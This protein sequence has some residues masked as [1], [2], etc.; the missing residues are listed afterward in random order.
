MEVELLEIRDFLAAQRP[1]DQLPDDALSSVPSTLSIRYVRRDHDIPDDD[2]GQPLLSV[3]RTGAAE[4]RSAGGE[5]LAR[6][7][8]GDLLGYRASP[9]DGTQPVR[10]VA[11]E[12][13]L[14]YQLPAQVVDRLC[15]EH[16]QFAYFF[17]PVG[18][19]RLRD[20]VR[21]LGEGQETQLNLMTT[22]LR[23]LIAR[24]PV[25]LPPTATIRETAER[26]S[27]ER[28]SSML[29]VE[30]GFLFGVVTDRD[31]RLR[32]IAQGLD[33]D[34]PVMEIMTG[35]PWTVDITAFAYEAL[36]FMA[37][38]GVHHLPVLDGDRVAGMVTATDF[39]ERH[40]TSAVYLAGDIY[41]QAT[42]A[43][44]QS[45]SAR[46]PHLFLNLAAAGATAERVGHV[47]TGVGDAVT[48]RLLELAE[49]KMGPP[50]VDYA[51]VTAG[52]QARNEQSVGSDQDN[53]L[54]LDD[55]YDPAA[56]GDYFREFTRFVCDGL[57]S[58]GYVH[59]P[60]DMMAMTD[61]WRLSLKE[62]QTKFVGWIDEP[63]PKSLMLTCVFF[64]V[65]YV[66]GDESLFKELRRTVLEKTRGNSIF[67]AHM[68]SN[69][70]SHQ[71]PLGFFRNFVLI[72]GG[73]HDQ[74]F[75][76]K[77]N[78][79]IPIV[80]LARVYSL[81][82]G[83]D[84]VNTRER[85]TAAVANGEISE[86]GAM[87]LRDALEFISDVRLKH[88]LRQ[89]RAGEPP[90]N[91]V[92]PRYLSDFERSHLKDAFAVVRTMQRVLAQRFKT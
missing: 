81:A 88:Q 58:C 36:L 17:A 1:F 53:A 5:L 70:L 65:R 12:D 8:E 48:I 50:P 75:D 2:S 25:T 54:I 14:I 86:S 89:L 78:G 24:E 45:A 60:G 47:I 44:L 90:D 91:F 4:I 11:I 26:M 7:G 69:A 84:A 19:D 38:H 82:S 41:Q 72:R 34:R 83:S 73:E 20:A 10:G 33:Y 51:W 80:D 59:C 67:L 85:L 22:P 42:V 31:L 40:S 52:S 23:N 35:A 9:Q 76:L 63:E 66:Y 27:A 18:G 77:H 15:E 55:R 32:V 16:R 71:P 56:H 39:F 61:E 46:I 68:T 13:S 64:D 79:I 3:I 37:R 30:Q 87:D 74:R 62:W 43:G 21:S 29:I 28:I 92:S 6:L 57:N 49:M